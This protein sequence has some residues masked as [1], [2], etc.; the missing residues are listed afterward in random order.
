MDTRCPTLIDMV[1]LNEK[2]KN[3]KKGFLTEKCGAWPFHPFATWSIT[4]TNTQNTLPNLTLSLTNE[5]HFKTKCRLR[6]I[7]PTRHMSEI[8]F[9][10]L[11]LSVTL[12]RPPT[13]V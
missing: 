1:I 7:C 5:C 6:D 12:A 3:E 8:Q 10:N 11:R 4:I 9:L 2:S 13:L